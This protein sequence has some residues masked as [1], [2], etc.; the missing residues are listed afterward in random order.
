MVPP[1]NRSKVMT[2]ANCCEPLNVGPF[3]M[4]QL[5]AKDH[6]RNFIFIFMSDGVFLPSIIPMLLLKQTFHLD[7]MMAVYEICE[8]QNPSIK[9]ML[10]VNFLGQL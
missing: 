4:E 3:L 10:K 2:E 5:T 7:I 8:Q 6:Q 9:P 1:R